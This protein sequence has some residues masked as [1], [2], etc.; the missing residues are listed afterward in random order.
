MFAALSPEVLEPEIYSP[1]FSRARTRNIIGKSKEIVD[2]FRGAVPRTMEE[3]T[4]RRSHV[5][6]THVVLGTAY[7]IASGIVVDRRVFRVATPRLKL[8]VEKTPERME[9]D[10][11]KIVLRSRWI[12]FS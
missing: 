4:L 12:R 5:K 6:P 1:G 9:Q 11:L 2:Q 8:S 7:N 3:L 10:L